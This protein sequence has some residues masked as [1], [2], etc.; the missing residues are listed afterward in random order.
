MSTV[1]KL[2]PL[3]VLLGGGA[4]GGG[5][6]YYQHLEKV[7]KTHREQ[8]FADLSQCLLGKP[9]PGDADALAEISALEA[10]TAHR[11]LEMRGAG[12]DAWPTR[13]SER[14]NYL[15][16][17]IR[18]SSFIDQDAKVS[19]LE[20]VD[21]LEKEIEKQP[22]QHASL[23]GYV[24]AL[25]RDAPKL[26]LGMAAQS[27]VPG[28]P[29]P[30]V[31]DGDAHLTLA[32][33]LPIDGGPEWAFLTEKQDKSAALGICRQAPD[34]LVCKDFHGEGTVS[35]V[36]TWASPDFISVADGEHLLVL[37]DGQA[38]QTGL[39]PSKDVYVDASGTVFSIGAEP[40]SSDRKLIVKPMGKPAKSAPLADALSAF[41]ELPE[42][43]AGGARILGPSL[44]VSGPS[45]W[46]IPM[47]EGA[48]LGKPIDIGGGKAGLVRGGC[49]SGATFIMEVVEPAAAF[50]F[51]DEQ[52][53]LGRVPETSSLQSCG[54]S[55]EMWERGNR[56][57]TPSGCH[58][59]IPA[60]L[61]ALLPFETGVG[62]A[63]AHVVSVWGVPSGQGILVR[64]A[65]DNDLAD[66]PDTLILDKT[67]IEKPPRTAVFGGPTTALVFAE[68]DD[69]VVGV[70]VTA[71]GKIQPIHVDWK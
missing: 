8:L 36:G 29:R 3:F 26:G 22:K 25:F 56:M 39:R 28:P 44:I 37:H 40:M 34:G 55:G 17:A 67:N 6:L 23:T 5:Y 41:S 60:P 57:C 24:A 35:A 69:Q 19:L 45:L 2:I 27:T 59:P 32:E 12:A 4:A 11:P 48:K 58:D 62:F 7:D 43:A 9:I 47:L 20:K 51:F 54:R 64:V 52:H 21:A 31:M 53:V 15:T 13:C 68:I 61:R 14:A 71:E 49:R 46:R 63:G 50:V 65:G 70:N 10:R 30:N 1:K 18:D 42:E 38:V 16:G 33:I 66:T